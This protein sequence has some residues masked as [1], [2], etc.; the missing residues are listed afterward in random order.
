MSADIQVIWENTNDG[1]NNTRYHNLLL[2]CSL[3]ESCFVSTTD[4]PSSTTN[5]TVDY[6]DDSDYVPHIH[7]EIP[8]AC[9]NTKILKHPKKTDLWLRKLSKSNS[10]SKVPKGK[11]YN[12][13]MKFNKKIPK[14]GNFRKK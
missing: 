2:I 14:R 7:I 11:H 6:A 3:F 10:R 12:K 1:C 8:L 5:T 9:E 4:S 13:K